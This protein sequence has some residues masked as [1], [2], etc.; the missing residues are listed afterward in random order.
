MPSSDVSIESLLGPFL[1][2]QGRLFDLIK[3]LDNDCCPDEALRGAAAAVDRSYRRILEIS[4]TE[5][6]ADRGYTAVL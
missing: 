4:Q 2:C 5:G 1:F 3:R 6:G